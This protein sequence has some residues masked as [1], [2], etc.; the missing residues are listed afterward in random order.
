MTVTE[1][2][3]AWGDFS[4]SLVP[5]TPSSIITSLNHAWWSIIRVTKDHTELATVNAS[6]SGDLFAGVMIKRPDR[7]TMSGHSVTM[8]LGANSDSKELHSE[9]V[10][11]FSSSTPI[12]FDGT[13]AGTLADWVNHIVTNMGCV[14]SLGMTPT[15]PWGSA[16]KIGGIFIRKPPKTLL[17]TWICPTFGVGYRVNTNLTLDVGMASDLWP[18]PSVPPLA[19]AR[20]GRDMGT[21]ITLDATELSLEVSYEDWCGR[22]L[23]N[24]EAPAVVGLATNPISVGNPKTGYP[25]TMLWNKLINGAESSQSTAALAQAEADR[26][27]AVVLANAVKTQ[28]VNVSTAEYDVTANVQP[29]DT[30]GVFDIDEGLFDQTNAQQYRGRW[31]WPVRL[32]VAE[33]QW[34]IREGMGVY[35]DNRHNDGSTTVVDLT[36]FVAWESGDTTLTVGAPPKTLA[37]R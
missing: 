29:G 9:E 15:T 17:D 36:D 33:V 2:K 3:Q 34:P 10:G 8:Y 31:T 30:I 26:L 24:V 12:A 1:T 23:V 20:G 35:L 18:V 4:I 13:S 25:N 28:S 22:A 16:T 27:A 7:L 14:L 32:T 6:R 11:P 5:D 21:P 37:N 19:I